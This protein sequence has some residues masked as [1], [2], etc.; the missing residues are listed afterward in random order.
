[1]IV[2]NPNSFGSAVET[3]SIILQ[4]VVHQLGVPKVIEPGFVP[5]RRTSKVRSQV[6]ASIAL[7]GPLPAENVPFEAYLEGTQATVIR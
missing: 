4:L 7:L 5:G 1:M 6:L 3:Q 2:E